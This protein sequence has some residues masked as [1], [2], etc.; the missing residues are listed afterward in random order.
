[1]IP[2][3]PVI[4]HNDSKCPEEKEGDSYKYEGNQPTNYDTKGW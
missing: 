1:M 3:D 4:A 2:V